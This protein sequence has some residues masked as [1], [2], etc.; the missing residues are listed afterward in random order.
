MKGTDDN[1]EKVKIEQRNNAFRKLVSMYI[2]ELSKVSQHISLNTIIVTTIKNNS[3]R[4][5]KLF[6]SSDS[7]GKLHLEINDLLTK[8]FCKASNFMFRNDFVHDIKHIISQKSNDTT[9]CVFQ[10]MF[11]TKDD[12]E[13]FFTDDVSFVTINQ[14]EYQ[15]NQNMLSN[16]LIPFMLSQIVKAMT[17]NALKYSIEEDEYEFVANYMAVKDEENNIIGHDKGEDDLEINYIRQK[18]I[19]RFLRYSGLLDHLTIINLSSLT[20]ETAEC[21]ASMFFIDKSHNLAF[22]TNEDNIRFKNSEQYEILP[23]NYRLIRKL[24]EIAN[25]E[26]GLV[27]LKK[28]Y[29]I[30]PRILGLGKKQNI[31]DSGDLMKLSFSGHMKWEINYRDDDVV[32]YN[33]GIYKILPPPVTPESEYTNAIGSLNF[34]DDRQK[35]NIKEIVDVISTQ[36]SGTML[37]VAKEPYIKQEAERLC[38]AGRGIE[39]CKFNL[40]NHK[41]VLINISSIDGA[42]LVDI[43]GNCHAIGVILDGIVEEGRSNI[44]RGARYNSAVAYINDRSKI[45]KD[46]SNNSANFLAVI[47]SEDN[48][49]TIVSS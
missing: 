1:M 34:L 19:E 14:S 26:Y 6:Y 42:I 38:N 17:E 40:V 30:P 5:F 43:D 28:E 20:Y 15:R 18:A 3:E 21:E 8:H 9:V 39:I 36:K 49:V 2:P 33:N 23:E 44:G 27:V 45:Y 22:F 29:R 4:F 16:P 13:A 46:N 10:R 25:N 12:P 32:S 24:L 7:L 41:D 37:I 47:V 31:V 35:D 11:I 48:D